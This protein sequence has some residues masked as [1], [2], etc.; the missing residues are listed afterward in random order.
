MKATRSRPPPSAALAVL[1][2]CVL[3][4]PAQAQSTTIALRGATLIDGT[5]APP[6]AATTILVRQGEITAVT[7]D[8]EAEVPEDARVIDVSDQYVIP[9][10]ADMHV[11]FASGGRVARDPQTP[12]RVVRQLA[13]RR[14]TCPDWG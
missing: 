5:G 12:D 9:G 1:L 6:R 10:L 14:S 8:D 3:G 13:P 4:V 7:P 11:H 2:C